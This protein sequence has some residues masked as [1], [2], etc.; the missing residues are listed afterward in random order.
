[1]RQPN[2]EIF[3]K[4]ELRRLLDWLGAIASPVTFSEKAGDALFY[5]TRFGTVV[6]TPEIENGPFIS[7]YFPNGT[8][9][10]TDVD[11][12]RQAATELGCCVRCDPGQAFPSIHLAS[13]TFLEMEGGDEG[14]VEWATEP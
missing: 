9:W 1:M 14:L 4:C 12:A 13:D 2:I 6:V 8:P 10:D 7:A 3:V 11:C 5:E